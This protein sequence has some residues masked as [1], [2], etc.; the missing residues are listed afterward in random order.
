MLPS[1]HPPRA[2][3]GERL[4]KVSGVRYV[5]Q[6][7]EFFSV[8]AAFEGKVDLRLARDLNR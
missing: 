4:L 1:R 3:G 2:R 6:D 8:D 7:G 5:V